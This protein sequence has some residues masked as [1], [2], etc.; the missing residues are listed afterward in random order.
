MGTDVNGILNKD[1]R[2]FS[3]PG[4][5]SLQAAQNGA[6]RV[7]LFRISPCFWEL[8]AK[9]TV[10]PLSVAM[11]MSGLS[12]SAYDFEISMAISFTRLAMSSSAYINVSISLFCIYDGTVKSAIVSDPVFIRVSGTNRG[13]LTQL[14]AHTMAVKT[15]IYIISDENGMKRFRLLKRLKFLI[16]CCDY[17]ATAPA[18]TLAP[19]AGSPSY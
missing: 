6:A 9:K 15:N 11:T 17:L 3:S 8:T 1:A 5:W 18:L 14:R 19:S 16:E 2:V 4:H 10:A 12:R 7:H 13:L